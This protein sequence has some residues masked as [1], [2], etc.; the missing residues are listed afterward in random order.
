METKYIKYLSKVYDRKKIK[1]KNK[2]I[3]ELL[4]SIYTH[5]YNDYVMIKI[6]KYLAPVDYQLYPIVRKLYLL[7]FQPA[8]WNFTTQ[9]NDMTTFITF[10]MNKKLKTQNTQLRL[11]KA[12]KSV[13]DNSKLV[14]VEKFN[15]DSA[16][17][18]FNSKDLDHVLKLLKVRKSKKQ[19]LPG[20]GTVEH[21]FK[22][23][24]LHKLLNELPFQDIEAD[25]IY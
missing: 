13:F 12:L 17:I 25:D 19:V 3:K 14:K 18:D 21:T 4:K 20:A 10:L 24:N 11:V 6:G 22:I 5:Q 8:G 9:K 1:N 15:F 16:Q 2:H 23:K 7:G